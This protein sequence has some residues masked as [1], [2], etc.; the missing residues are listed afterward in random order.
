MSLTSF[1]YTEPEERPEF[2]VFPN[3]EYKFRILE[4]NEMKETREKRTPMLPI[5][6]E[7]AD[8]DG[9]TTVV[10]DNLLFA[11]NTLWKVKAFLKC[12][13]PQINEGRDINFEDPE[14]LDWLKRKTGTAKLKS[15]K[16]LGKDY[17]RNAVDAYVAGKSSDAP[18]T[19]Q[20]IKLKVADD[21]EDD[22][23]PF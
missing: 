15:E 21:E 14:F 7:F 3:G 19:A 12:V 16:V 11:E 6:L 5:K 22:K 8:D 1:K 17:S 9:K 13:Y 23:I 18:P 2:V 10:Y 20:N 4:I